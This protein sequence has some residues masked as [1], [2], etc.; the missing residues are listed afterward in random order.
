MKRNFTQSFKIQ[1]VEKALNRDSNIS[2]KEVSTSL[3]I[4]FSTLNKWIVKARN[5][6]FETVSVAKLNG[7]TK[8]KRPQD[9]SLEERL[10]MVVACG[11]LAGEALSKYCRKNG[12]YPHQ[13]NQWKLDFASGKT[14]ETK[15]VSRA[16]MKALKQ[17]NKFLKKDLNR[18]DKA[19]AETAALL[20]LQKKVN[21]V[22]GR[23]DEDNSQ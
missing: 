19:L 13:V 5:Q 23:D 1:A 6:E 15:T 7:M 10:N 14:E 2:L 12:I 22:W 9:W 20:V 3:G 21:A 16:E 11:A 17:E 4:G 18:K 8:E